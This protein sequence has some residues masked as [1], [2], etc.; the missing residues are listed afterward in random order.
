MDDRNKSVVCRVCGKK[1][2]MRTQRYRVVGMT[3]NNGV[4]QNCYEHNGGCPQESE[5]GAHVATYVSA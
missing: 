3:L 1:I 2:D 4:P 5:E